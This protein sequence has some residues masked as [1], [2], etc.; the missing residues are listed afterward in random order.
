MSLQERLGIIWI[1]H[2]L[3][4]QNV[5]SRSPIR[6]SEDNWVT[7]K[8]LLR[9]SAYRLPT[10][11]K[12]EH[13]DLSLTPYFEDD[14][15]PFTF[16]GTVDIHINALEDD[17]K[18]IVMHCKDIEIKS[19]LIFQLVNDDEELVDLLVTDD[20]AQCEDAYSFLRIN[21]VNSLQL[22]TKYI[23]RIAFSGNLQKDMTG[24]YRSWYYDSSGRKR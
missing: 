21:T 20:V 4:I 3:L 14:V 5:V 8:T 18:Q 24:F 13:Y 10:T 9:D 6:N 12:P 11:T 23:V 19:I 17:V 16:D 7:F 15:R 22:G 1:I 2:G